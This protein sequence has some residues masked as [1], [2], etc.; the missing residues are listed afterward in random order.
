MISIGEVMVFVIC[1]VAF[2]HIIQSIFGLV[3]EALRK[4]VE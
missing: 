1:F 4:K 2:S 3:K